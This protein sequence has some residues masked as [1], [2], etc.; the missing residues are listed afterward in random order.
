MRELAIFPKE[1]VVFDETSANWSPFKDHNL[2]FL[3]SIERYANHRL[4]AMGHV[5]LNEVYDHLGLPR[6]PQG[7]ITGWIKDGDGA[8]HIVFEYTFQKDA[9]VLS[10]NIDGIMYDKI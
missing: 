3:G 1:Y 9:I 7:A 5:F 10:F 8:G 6:T 2:T 4:Q